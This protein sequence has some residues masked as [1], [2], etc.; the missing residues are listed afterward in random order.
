HVRPTIEADGV[1]GHSLSRI[2]DKALPIQH[3]KDTRRRQIKHEGG[4]EGRD[5][6]G[7][8]P[9]V[10]LGSR[11]RDGQGAKVCPRDLDHWG[12]G[13][14]QRGQKP[15]HQSNYF[16]GRNSKTTPDI[17]SAAR[18]FSGGGERGD[19]FLT[20]ESTAL[21]NRL[22]PELRASCTRVTSPERPMKRSTWALRFRRSSSGMVSET[23]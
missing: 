22:L 16:Q 20:A 5:R 9:I 10:A 3:L 12:L 4:V 1:G 8:A 21:S 2:D 6:L 19:A 23:L 7:P 13:H 15:D 11:N 14:S 18:K 17:W